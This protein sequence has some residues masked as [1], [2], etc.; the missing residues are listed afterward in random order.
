MTNIQD[1]N[2]R[3]F[4]Y[5]KPQTFNIEN[6]KEMISLGA[7]VNVRDEEGCTPLFY[8]V[9]SPESRKLDADFLGLLLKNGADIN[10]TDNTGQTPLE[11]YVKLS[12]GLRADSIVLLAELGAQVN[13]SNDFGDTALIL[14]AK[15]RNLTPKILETFLSLGADANKANTMGS[16]ALIASGQANT[17]TSEIIE[18]MHDAGVD[19]SAKNKRGENAF[20]C[21][22]RQ[23]MRY[24][25]T[26]KLIDTMVKY[27]L[28][29][30]E[31]SPGGKTL[32]TLIPAYEYNFDETFESRN[33]FST[34]LR[35]FALEENKEKRISVLLDTISSS[36][37][38]QAQK[39]AYILGMACIL[40]PER[41]K[42][43][44]DLLKGF[45]AHGFKTLTTLYNIPPEI[46]AVPLLAIM[47]EGTHGIIHSLK[48]KQSKKVVDMLLESL[49]ENPGVAVKFLKKRMGK[50]IQKWV[51]Q[52]IEGAEPLVA[53]LAPIMESVLEKRK[54]QG[55]KKNIC[56]ELIAF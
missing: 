11:W 30:N 1:L 4:H 15:H 5:L 13:H 55:K 24:G 31:E 49:D 20:I 6:A 8:Y 34:F 25:I 14:A 36:R 17:I 9:I 35:L 48:Q 40:Y 51:E 46:R 18:I 3:L 53:R 54:S 21:L 41:N 16:T 32:L 27:G 33:V 56:P 39:A 22:A 12:Y 43:V 45:L 47:S 50:G 2:C 29:V 7:D 10:A 28:D 52:G 44:D 26:R 23:G 38:T 37:L 19:L 42:A